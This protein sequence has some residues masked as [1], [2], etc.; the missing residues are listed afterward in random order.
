MSYQRIATPRI[1]TDNIN[2]MLGLGKI[3]TSSLTQSGLTSA[4]P[5]EMFDMKPSNLVDLGGNG[6]STTHYI[7]INTNITSDSAQDS[8]FIAILGH[9]FEEADVKFRIQTHDYSGFASPQ[10]PTMTNVVNS[11][12]SSG[13]AVP[14]ANG[15]SLATFSATSDNQ[16][17]R[18]ELAP[19]TGNYDAD[20]KI[21]A[22]LIGEYIDFPH[23]PDMNVSKKLLFDGVKKQQSIGGQT[24]ANASFL[25]GADWYHEPYVNS[26]NVNSNPLR[27]TGRISLDMNFSYMN[28]TDVFPQEFN[29]NSYLI[30][31]DNIIGNLVQRTGG[32]MYPFMFQFDNSANTDDDSYLWC[33]LNGEPTFSQVAHQ[34]WNCDVSLIEEF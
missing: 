11:T 3:T 31:S 25:S 17:I 16:W 15:W 26:G 22:I 18:I 21:G 5:V 6:V 1:Y 12:V 13:Y 23:A 14:S 32:G 24:Y 10:T 7:K 28:D 9:N 2:W 30:G 19:G 8:N 33:R 27:R 34:T 20:T 4:S 29:D